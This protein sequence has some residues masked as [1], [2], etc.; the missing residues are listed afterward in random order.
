[1]EVLMRK[2]FFVPLPFIYRAQT[3][4]HRRGRPAV[5]ALVLILCLHGLATYFKGLTV[6]NS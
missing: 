5:P 2:S 3:C 1:M 6:S 4:C